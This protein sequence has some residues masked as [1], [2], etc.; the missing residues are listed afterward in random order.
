MNISKM[1]WLHA[2]SF[3]F[4]VFFIFIYISDLFVNDLYQTMQTVAETDYIVSLIC[5]M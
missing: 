5:A 4:I 3:S 2:D 1:I